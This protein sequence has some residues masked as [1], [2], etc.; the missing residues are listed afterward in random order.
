MLREAIASVWS[1]E[2]LLLP[3]G[4]AVRLPHDTGVTVSKLERADVA[5]GSDPASHVD[6]VDPVSRI[7]LDLDPLEGVGCGRVEVIVPVTVASSEQTQA[8]QTEGS[9]ADARRR[10]RHVT[11][12]SVSEEKQRL[13]A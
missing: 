13:E 12:R 3:P 8:F 1:A 10:Q 6:A 9:T 7:Q 5:A 11:L 2:C 4:G